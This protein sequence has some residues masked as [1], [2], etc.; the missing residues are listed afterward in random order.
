MF[1]TV[2]ESGAGRPPDELW[3]HSGVNGA[4]HLLIKLKH[5]SLIRL[6]LH[7]NLRGHGGSAI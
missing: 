3:K 2:P 7:I 6:I 5:T 1:G 4:F